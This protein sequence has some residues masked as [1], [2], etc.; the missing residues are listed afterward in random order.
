[1]KQKGKQA[2]LGLLLAAAAVLA[3]LS[4]EALAG[5]GPWLR[6]LSLSGGSG[7]AAAWATV[8][9][10]TALPALGLLWRGRSRWDLLLLLAAGEIFGGLYFL[11]N[12]TLLH[13][14]VPG[15]AAAS[16]WGLAA[17]GAVGATV[18][19]WAVLRALAR[20]EA[21][22]HLGRTLQRLLLWSALLLGGL[23]IWSQGTDL[24]DKL[25]AVA[26]A[27]TAPGVDLLPTKAVLCVLAA[28]D[29]LPT[30]LACAVLLWGGKLA[31][32]L[33]ADPFGE[34]TVALAERL[35]RQCAAVASASVLVCTAGNLLQMLLFS[36][37]YSTHFEVSFPFL[38]V[39]LAAALGLLCR[40]FRRAK[41]VSDDN[42]TII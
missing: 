6:E 25:R 28:A 15:E 18:L 40:Y 12:P 33:E 3:V 10:L 5:F 27:N 4:R 42:E 20:L 22:E 7:N 11:V 13:P 19:S 35:S 41:A 1:M 24:R 30:L 36:R 29:L 17:A 34:A 39:L 32:A 38:T 9:G 8:L 16:F 21:A 37:L 14:E 31:L 26:E 23:S 2:G